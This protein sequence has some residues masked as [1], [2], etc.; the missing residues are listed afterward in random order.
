MHKIEEELLQNDICCK[1]CRKIINLDIK[2]I[3]K[4]ISFKNHL[5]QAHGVS[6]ID[7]YKLHNEKICKFCKERNGKILITKINGEIVIANFDLCDDSKCIEVRNKLNCNS[8]EYVSITESCSKEE[9]LKIIHTRNSTPFYIGNHNSAE[10][11]SLN[12][13]INSTRNIEHY[14]NKINPDTNELYT[15]EEAKHE[16]TII[17][18]VNA[19]KQ[20]KGKRKTSTFISNLKGFQKIYGG[21]QG[22]IEYEAF[23]AKLKNREPLVNN[24]IYSLEW[25]KFV[26][27]NIEGE[28]S[29]I[30]R[31]NYLDF[32]ESNEYYRMFLNPNS[33]ER[34]FEKK[35]VIATYTSFCL[36]HKLF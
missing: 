4:L 2:R 3:D 8:I 13:K 31:Q 23:C 18:C 11:Y 7:Y 33:A 36:Y 14:L 35:T 21:K 28:K 26:Y 30:H 17:Q 16:I 34:F 9:A 20:K 6:I 27:G 24:R 12:Q 15:E 22:K 5:I 32:I 10:E 29:Y 25:Y 1:I 19:S